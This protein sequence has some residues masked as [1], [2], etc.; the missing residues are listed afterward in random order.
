MS[1]I[2]IGKWRGDADG[3][4]QVVSGPVGRRKVHYQAPPA[5]ALPAGDG[6][7]PDMGQRGNWRTGAHQGR[8]CAPEVCRPASLRRWQW[9]HHARCGR[10]VPRSHRWQPAQR[11]Y[12]LSAQIQLER[13][14]Y[15]DVLEHTQKGSLDVTGRLSWFLGTLTRAVASAQT[16]LDAV[17]AR[18]AS[19]NAGR[20]RQ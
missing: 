20:A 16:T 14:D 12:S 8:P 11:F 19:G 17:L 13:K 1:K 3:P 10:P 2:T 4:M 7:I 15:Y 5:D 18:H 9:A 6:E